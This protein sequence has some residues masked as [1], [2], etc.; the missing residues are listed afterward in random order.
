[1]PGAERRGPKRD[2]AGPAIISIFAGLL[3]SERVSAITY[4]D[5]LGLLPST[6]FQQVSKN[7]RV[8]SSTALPRYERDLQQS[9]GVASSELGLFRL[10]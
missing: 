8:I 9:S 7:D 3:S 6:Q 4:H 1:L 10:S 2:P 5:A